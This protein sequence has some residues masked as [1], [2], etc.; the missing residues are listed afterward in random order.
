MAISVML[1]KQDRLARY[2]YIPDIFE[3]EDEMITNNAERTE[4]S[5]VC[6]TE[7]EQSSK[8]CHT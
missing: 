4:I 1:N 3:R 6:T 8:D 5:R 7:K 2:I